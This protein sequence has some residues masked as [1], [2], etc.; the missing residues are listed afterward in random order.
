MPPPTRGLSRRD[1]RRR[2]APGRLWR[3]GKAAYG[4]ADLIRRATRCRPVERGMPPVQAAPRLRGCCERCHEYPGKLH[5][6]P[7]DP[8]GPFINRPGVLTGSVC[9]PGQ[10]ARAAA[11]TVPTHRTSTAP[12]DCC[13]R[14][15]ERTACTGV[16][17][18]LSVIPGWDGECIGVPPVHRRH[19]Y[20]HRHP[21][22]RGNP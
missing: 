9:F 15:S 6:K 1:S 20:R 14:I 12:L 5:C 8:P 21:S 18:V 13:T 4:C 7:L 16:A 3:K 2:A 17:G 19:P 11:G 10:T 22:S